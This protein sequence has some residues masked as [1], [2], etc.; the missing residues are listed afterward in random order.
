MEFAYRRFPASSRG[1]RPV[2]YIHR[3]VIPVSLSVGKEAIQSSALIDSGADQCTFPG[4]VAKD[5]GLKIERGSPRIFSG[6]GGSVM[7][8][9]HTTLIT[10]ADVRIA[11]EVYYS[12]QWDDM[13][14][15][16]LVQEGFFSRF[17]V[18]FDYKKKLVHLSRYDS[19]IAGPVISHLPAE[20]SV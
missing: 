8:Y 19:Q 7:A 10:V 14:F 6:I 20:C 16:L 13:P 1:V 5:L 12:H 9:R 3:P 17:R 2:Q 15:G 11:V 4:R 18:H